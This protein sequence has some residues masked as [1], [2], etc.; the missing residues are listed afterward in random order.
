M[1]K[2]ACVFSFNPSSWVSC[3]KIVFNLHKAYELVPGVELHNYNYNSESDA[4]EVLQ[5]AEKIHSLNPDVIS[6]LDHKP[7]PLVLIQALKMKYR[8]MK[9]PKIIFHLF[10]DFTLYYNEWAKLA[11]I[12]TDVPV[13][14]VV[15]SHRQKIL[16][17]KFLLPPHTSVVCPFPVKPQEFSLDSNLRE[18]QRGQWGA[19][20]EEMVFVFTGRLS[21]QKRIHLLLKSFSDLCEQNPELKARLYLYGYTDHLGDQFL[22]KWEVEGEYFRKL[23]RLYTGLPK[24]SQDRIHFMGAVPNKE[25]NSVYNGAD[26]LLNLSVH[27]DEDYGMSVAEAQF[28]GLP[29]LLS[30]WGGLASFTHSTLPEMVRFVPVTIGVKSKIIRMGDVMSAYQKLLSTKIFSGDARSRLAHEARAKFSVEAASVIIGALVKEAPRNFTNFSPLLKKILER[31]FLTHSPYLTTK[32]TIHP[33]FREI[34]SAYVR[35]N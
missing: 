10:G 17:D 27:N 14:F 24:A 18:V 19:S 2:I 32:K 15:A 1:Q 20:D 29:C 12:L 4:S 21:R 13:E 7:H 16:I 26:Y 3:Q 31:K 5:V 22:G 30:D 35:E 6:I 25:L 28:C 23:H 33:I 8:T 34:Y 9:L 11:L